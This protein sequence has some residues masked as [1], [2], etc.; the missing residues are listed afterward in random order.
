MFFRG[1]GGPP[2]PTVAA[3]PAG[4]WPPP[5]YSGILS[6]DNFIPLYGGDPTP[7][8]AARRWL[9]DGHRGWPSPATASWTSRP[10][11]RASLIYS[12]ATFLLSLVYVPLIL[13]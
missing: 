2:T 1:L 7:W 12:V 4:S 8:E 5:W 10:I 13:V 11:I 6:A 3:R 9:N